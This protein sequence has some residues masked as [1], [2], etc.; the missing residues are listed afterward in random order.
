[1]LIGAYNY[2]LC[3]II[4]L[5]KFPDMINAIYYVYI[6]KYFFQAY[7]DIWSNCQ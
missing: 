1:M 2:I 3:G 7:N 5:E 6:T 4:Y